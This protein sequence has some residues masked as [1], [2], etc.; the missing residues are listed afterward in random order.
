MMLTKNYPTNERSLKAKFT[1]CALSF[2]LFSLLSRLGGENKWKL[3]TFCNF[4][5]VYR[6]PTKY[7]IAPQKTYFRGVALDISFMHCAIDN[8]VNDKLSY[9]TWAWKKCCQVNHT[10]TLA[11]DKGDSC[12]CHVWQGVRGN[13][14]MYNCAEL[15]DRPLVFF[16][17]RSWAIL[18][19]VNLFLI[20]HDFWLGNSL[21]ENSFDIKIKMIMVGS[22]SHDSSASAVQHVFAQT[23]PP[24]PPPKQQISQ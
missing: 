18:Q 14:C 4:V 23:I 2:V 9:L 1:V 5:K 13:S 20:V 17:R 22:F 6:W 11:F 12:Y 3:P 7:C 8:Y 16:R 19:G 10:Q 24:P 21:C 15:K